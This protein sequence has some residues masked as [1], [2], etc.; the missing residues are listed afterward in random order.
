MRARLPFPPGA[1]EYERVIDAYLESWTDLAPAQE[2]RR[3]LPAAERM[4][5]LHRA[6]SWRRLMAD[7]AR[8][9]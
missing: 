1:P 2:L 8:G 4:S 5:A 3:L 6:E 9:H 7:A